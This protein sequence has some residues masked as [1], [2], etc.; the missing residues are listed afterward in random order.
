MSKLSTVQA[1]CPPTLTVLAA[2]GW[3]DDLD[4]ILLNLTSGDTDSAGYALAVTGLT[5]T[6]TRGT[7]AINANGAVT[8]RPGT[9]FKYLA[10]GTTATD[11]F[12]YIVS[13][14]HGGS[15]ASTATITVAGTWQ[16]PVAKADTAFTVANQPVVIDVLS[17]DS[18]P[19]PGVVL[20]VA[21][22]NMT[23]A[24][25]NATI[26]TDG[27]LTYS[28]GSAF[29]YL[30]IGSTA[31]DRFSYTVS[32]GHGNT[33]TAVTTVTIAG[34]W[35]PPTA[36]A[37]VAATDANKSVTI[38]VLGVV[39]DV[40][41]DQILAIS[42]VNLA[43]TKGAVVPNPDGTV[44]YTPSSSFLRLAAGSLAVDRFRYTVSDSHGVSSSGTVMV[45]VDGVN[46][47]PIANP[48]T[49][50]TT[51]A[52]GVWLGLANN[53][54]DLNGSP[55]SVIS[56]GQTGTRGQVSL[57]PA[58]T[59]G[60]YYVPG[61]AFANLGAGH[62][63]TDSFTYTVS[64][65]HGNTAS[66][67]ATV[68]IAGV[69]VKPA[70]QNQTAATDAVH[71]VTIDVLANATNPNAGSLTVT[72]VNLKGT[73]GAVAMNPNGTITYTPGAAF[74]GLASGS[75]TTDSFGYTISDGYG[76]STTGNASVIVTAPG[77]SATAPRAFYVA[78]TGNDSWAGDLAQPNAAGTDGP[79][80]TLA[81]AQVKMNA[82]STVKTTYIE[83][84]DYYLK[85]GL[86]LTSEDRGEFWLAMPGQTPVIHGGQTVTGWSQ[87]SNGIWTAQAHSGAFTSGGG[88]A[89][90]F[91]NG[92]RE[93][94][95]RYPNE[96]PA[97]PVQ[98]GWLSAAA[99]LPGE[100]TT[101]SFQFNPSDLP[102]L[103]SISGLYV[104]IYQ[105]NGWAS[106]ALPVASVNYATDTINLAG[107]TEMPIGAGSRYYLYNAASQLDGENEWFYNPVYNTVSLDAP[108][109]FNGSGVSVGSLSSIFTVSHTSN[110]TIAGLTLTG[111]GTTGDGIN[112]TGSTGVTVAGNTISNVGNGINID[113]GG[114]NDSIQSNLIQEINDN[115]IQIYPGA[116][117]VTI[118]GNTIQTIGQLVN[119]SGICFTGS[120]NDTITNNQIQE[121][122]M[123][124]IG[125]GSV[126]GTSDASYNDNISFNTIRNAN[127]TTS[128]GGG[129]YLNGQQ[130]T[131]TGDTISYNTISGTSAAGTAN[132]SQL[133]F[134]SP[135]QLFSFGIYLD[136]YASGVNVRGNLLYSN[137]GGIDLHSGW[138]NTIANNV[139]DN[140]GVTALMD[141][142][143][144]WKGTGSQPSAGNVFTGNL[145]SNMQPGATLVNDEAAPNA[146]TF[147]GNF[148]DVAGLGSSAFITQSANGA[149]QAQSFATWQALGFDKGAVVGTPE[150][151]SGNYGSAAGSAASAAGI[152][153]AIINQTG[154]AGFTASV[155]YVPYGQHG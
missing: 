12:G 104:A 39:S 97:N 7:A 123:F 149:T 69:D 98:G 6:D 133:A 65:G 99:S 129:I 67:T 143:A 125:G 91:L 81:A 77:A 13:D 72:A 64:D 31:A 16:L 78:T 108:A 26:N 113:S 124:G 70:V 141:Q 107:S 119:G 110:V 76:G 80:A 63:A 19:E 25:G 152:G 74:D 28:P 24:K 53:D 135:S 93:I 40:Q 150:F 50:S 114:G 55:L 83:G 146:A 92:A 85:A 3:T 10:A 20:S 155:A 100:N 116:N 42:E 131:L 21:G 112:I 137:E 73:N 37:V 109:G 18:D 33:A 58:A 142:A 139:V 4:A 29:R 121:T 57:T 38:D 79:L 43:G 56:L 145:V 49:A 66:S 147:T 52:Q 105:Q 94:H 144:N 8:Y 111:T 127:R 102:S 122:A 71:P 46:S 11:T 30:A 153:S 62:T 61:P 88:G 60:A 87:G 9:A 126:I 140:S 47:P 101:S 103:G 117:S 89:D 96:A 17:G 14:G 27:T 75:A 132:A 35:A 134:L 22:L 86:N 118:Q 59:N 2:S 1:I 68:T 45:D 48:D 5:L 136:D 44:T 51:S 154:A 128:D 34:S 95:A 138:G 120:S 32:D 151:I 148:Y 54:V 82:S 36:G 130:Q 23:G 90:L 106:Y 84:G 41:P 115:G 15:A